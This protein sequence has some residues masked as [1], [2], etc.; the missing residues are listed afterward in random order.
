MSTNSCR[1]WIAGLAVVL[2]LLLSKSADAQVTNDPGPP[3]ESGTFWNN[4]YT[5]AEYDILNQ[6]KAE[7]RLLHFQEKLRLD[8]ERNNPAAV[9]HDARR[10]KV[11]RNRIAVDEWLIRKNQLYNP[12]CYPLPVRLDPMS[13]AAIANATRPPFAPP[14]PPAPGHGW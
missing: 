11:L 5:G 2:A 10:I 12:G 7:R 9:D 3:R 6:A 1:G 13:C 14:I 4:L 8:A